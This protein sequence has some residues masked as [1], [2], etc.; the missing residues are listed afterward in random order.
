MKEE[1]AGME[2]VMGLVKRLNKLQDKLIMTGTL[3]VNGSQDGG[4]R[5][6]SAGSGGGRKSKRSGSLSSL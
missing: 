4:S 2:V 3:S 1:K 5:S 6:G